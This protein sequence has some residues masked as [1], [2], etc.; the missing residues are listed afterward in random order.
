MLLFGGILFL[1]TIPNK[2]GHITA[3]MSLKVRSS[4]KLPAALSH[5]LTFGH[6]TNVYA[7]HR[8]TQTS[9]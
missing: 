6:C 2:K 5:L 4:Y 1:K 3:D 8:F 9:T 7:D